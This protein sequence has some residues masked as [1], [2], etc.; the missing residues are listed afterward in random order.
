MNFAQNNYQYIV[1]N[2]ILQQKNPLQ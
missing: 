1:K 2:I